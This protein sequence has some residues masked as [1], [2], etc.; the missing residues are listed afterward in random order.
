M[1]FSLALFATFLAGTSAAVQ[2][3][4]AHGAIKADSD[5]GMKLLSKARNLDEENEDEAE[6]E[7]QYSWVAG[8]SLKFQ[9]CHHV[10]QWNADADEDND[11]KIATK[12]LVRFRLCPSS[13]CAASKAGGCTG[14]YGDYVLDMST[15]V[16]AYY[17]AKQQKEEQDCENFM[18]YNCNCDDDDGQG[19]DFDEET[20]QYDCYAAAGMT[21]CADNNPYEDDE[22]NKEEFEVEKY[23]ECAQ[24]EGYDQEEEDDEERKLEDNGD[25]DEDALYVGPYCAEQGG[26]IYL[27]VFSDD[28]CTE[29]ADEYGGKT[30]FKE[31]TG[32]ALP[33]S[34]ES[35]VGAECVSCVEQQNED[36][37]NQDDADRVGEQCEQIYAAA[38]KCEENLPEGMVDEPNTG[39]CNYMEG[40][41][42]ARADGIMSFTAK[43]RNPVVTAF[44]VIFAMAFLALGFYVFYLR[45]RIGVKK[46]ALL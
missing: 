11:V 6:E 8:Y 1:K 40:I 39:A 28:T 21:S 10:Q 13:T 42:I 44:I 14:G 29:F 25:E 18:N 41:K 30:T 46:N 16:N 5:L 38:G 3:V 7:E 34:E 15:Y 12:R 2:R 17:E 32:E 26:A 19:D 23:M 24:L 43:K 20:C 35:I 37:D 22:Q 9:G 36:E 27:G 31:L 4:P 33:Y 45:K